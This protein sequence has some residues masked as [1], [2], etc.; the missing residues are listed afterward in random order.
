MLAAAAAVHLTVAVM[1]FPTLARN[2]FLYDDSFY[3]FQIARHIAAGDG[4]TFDG[5][6][7]TNGF[8]PLYVGMLVPLYVVA[9]RSETLPI[10][11]ALVLSALL[12]VGS[13]YLLYRLLARR[14]SETAATIAAAAW[15]FS[16]IVV[17]QGANGLE[18]SLA[19]FMLAASVTYY[20]ERVRPVVS[21]P[22]RRFVAL[23]ALLGASILARVDLGFLALVMC[24]DYLLVLRSR[25]VRN[26]AGWTRG[27][28]AAAA[29]GAV[30]CAP[31]VL[32]GVLAV[33][34]AVPESGR[35][36]RFLALSYAPFFGLGNSSMAVD[37]PTWSFM[38]ALLVRSIES[39]RVIPILHPLF[40]GTGKIGE[41]VAPEALETFASLVAVALLAGFVVWWFRRRRRPE[42]QSAREF[43]FLLLFG[44]VMIA[45]YSS[46]VYGVFFF[47]RYYYPIYFVAMI[48]AGLVIDDAIARVRERSPRTRRIA[49]AAC[50]V[51]AAALMFMGYTSAFRTTPVYRFY[52][53]ACWIRTHTDASETIGA[54]QS[55]AIG[56][57]SHRT[58]IDL[59]GKVDGEAYE[60]LRSHRLTEYVATA[61]VD[62]VMDNMNVLDLFLGPWSAAEKR[63]IESERVFT[64]GDYGLPGW[65]GYR[66]SSSTRSLG[67]SVTPG[68]ASHPA[69]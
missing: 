3:T 12:T 15:A 31:W 40:R 26:R 56:Y 2:G 64:G 42:G 30:V 57:L 6:H 11:F 52:D 20:L 23:G 61:G 66:P 33:G 16:P 62:I 9:G 13:A 50:G 41:R 38:S 19:L 34:S 17:R 60:A 35:A 29:T 51:Y 59:D 47:L 58:V 44:V 7:L 22:T 55:G 69:R 18:T 63:R 27:L 39:L 43:D 32:Y 37:G 68:P 8:Q 46:Y 1:D 24:L 65:I 53:A 14:V 5:V 36:T 10:H 49:L 28:A 4:P 21:P 67:A 45:S 25:T 54:F 48:F